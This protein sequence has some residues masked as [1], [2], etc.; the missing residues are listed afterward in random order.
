MSDLI[1]TVEQMLALP[2]GSITGPRRLDH[3][4]RAR[5]LVATML[6]ERG[7]SYPQIG[8]KLGGRDHST[9]IFAVR[10]YPDYAAV[11]PNLERVRALFN[12]NEPLILSV[13]HAREQWVR[14]RN[15]AVIADIKRNQP[16]IRIMKRHRLSITAYEQ[17]A[18]Q[19]RNGLAA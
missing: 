12:P 6:R 17:L 9:V 16:P 4:V 8:G 10:R 11:D 13:R 15:K 7:L 19:V 18:A 3:Y 14:D 2:E 5:G 1:R